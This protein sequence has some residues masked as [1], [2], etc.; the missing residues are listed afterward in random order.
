MDPALEMECAGGSSRREKPN[1]EVRAMWRGHPPVG[2]NLRALGMGIGPREPISRDP[3][4][5]C[6]ENT[7]RLRHEAG[8]NHIPNLRNR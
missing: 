7:Y 5:R 3:S 8:E 1:F 4:L 6:L 2:I